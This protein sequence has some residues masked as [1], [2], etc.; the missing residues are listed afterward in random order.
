MQLCPKEGN[1]YYIL[2]ATGHDAQTY[3]GIEP[4]KP[5]TE[6][7]LFDSK[8]LKQIPKAYILCTESEFINVSQP[9]FDKL[10]VAPRDENWTTYKI[11]SHHPVMIE[12]SKELADLF[13][14][15]NAL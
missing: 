4:L 2:N 10:T 11:K 9:M 6:L 5:F 8:K 1:P 15:I 3:Y 7:L 13:L 14:K 12:H